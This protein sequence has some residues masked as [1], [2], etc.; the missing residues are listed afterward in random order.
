WVCWPTLAADRGRG[1]RPPME[2]RWRLLDWADDGGRIYCSVACGI[3]VLV[4]MLARR[5]DEMQRMT[6]NAAHSLAWASGRLLMGSAGARCW[7]G[8]LRIGRWMMD[9]GGGAM[10]GDDEVARWIRRLGS[11]YE[12]SGRVDECVPCD[13]ALVTMDARSRIYLGK[14]GGLVSSWKREED[15]F[16]PDTWSM[17]GLPWS[18]MK[19]G[20]SCS[21]WPDLGGIALLMGLGD[22]SELG[23]WRRV[24]PIVICSVGVWM[25]AAGLDPLHAVSL[26][27][28]SGCDRPI[29]AGA[30]GGLL[31]SS[32]TCCCSD[33]LLPK[34]DR[35]WLGWK[36]WPALEKICKWAGLGKM[37][38][39][40]T[41]AP[42]SG[43]SL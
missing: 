33:E 3:M 37:M 9:A 26:E 29:G 17:E 41:G 36:G 27:M 35:C 18:Q 15:G 12:W 10:G 16:S 5:P 14:G 21:C 23:A 42:C 40:H 32:K 43:G 1:G 11:G 2:T 31:K 4:G 8:R 22:D 38:E 13:G 34:L 30:D 25:L 20:Q 28:G 7:I 24:L 19:E 39:H 6:E